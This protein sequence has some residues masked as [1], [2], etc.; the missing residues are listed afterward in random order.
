M[1]RVMNFSLFALIFYSISNDSVVCT[2]CVNRLLR[3]HLRSIGCTQR[4]T[5]TNKC[6]IIIIISRPCSAGEVIDI[7][8][9]FLH[10]DMACKL[11]LIVIKQGRRQ[12]I[13]VEQDGYWRSEG[14]EEGREG[15]REGGGEGGGYFL[16]PGGLNFLYLNSCAHDTTRTTLIL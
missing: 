9:W 13:H 14:G 1:E 8:N 10:I 5:C 4:L 3:P 15:G 11:L 16:K 12:S 6:M 7:A 2:K